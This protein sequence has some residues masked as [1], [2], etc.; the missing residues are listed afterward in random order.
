MHNTTEYKLIKIDKKQH[1][2]L[3]SEIYDGMHYVAV[4]NALR[5]MLRFCWKL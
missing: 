3:N 1:Y 2:N 4:G 5:V